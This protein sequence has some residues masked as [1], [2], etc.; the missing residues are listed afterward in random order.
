MPDLAA[1]LDVDRDALADRWNRLTRRLQAR[2]QRQLTIES[3][4]FLMG[5]QARGRGYE[6]DLEKEAKQTLIM[7][8]TY[9][10]FEAIGLYERVGMEDDGAWIWE[11]TQPMPDLPL[12]DQE[13]L[14][15][16]AILAYFDAEVGDAD[17]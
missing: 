9:C 7:E 17:G 4:L 3:I 11:R 6:P 8:G 16:V 13:T 1:L 15:Q 5:I 10:A 14:L 12:D 2:F